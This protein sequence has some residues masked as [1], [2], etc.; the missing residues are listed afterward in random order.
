MDGTEPG[1]QPSS[2]HFS[3]SY[4]LSVLSMANRKGNAKSTTATAQV[5]KPEATQSARKKMRNA[6]SEQQENEAPSGPRA[7]K[8]T[9]L[10]NAVWKQGAPTGACKRA[11]SPSSMPVSKTKQ[12]EVQQGSFPQPPHSTASVTHCEDES[13][14]EEDSGAVSIPLRVPAAPKKPSKKRSAA[15]SQS[16]PKVTKDVFASDAEE[17]DDEQYSSVTETDSPFMTEPED[18]VQSDDDGSED[19]N[20]VAGKLTAAKKRF[21]EEQPSWSGD[22]NKEP[23]A[24]SP[25][26]FVIRG[27]PIVISSDDGDAVASPVSQ[28]FPTELL[29]V[30]EEPL[31]PSGVLNASHTAARANKKKQRL[32]AD[33]IWPEYTHVMRSRHD[34]SLALRYQGIELKLVLQKA[35]DSIEGRTRFR[36]AFPTLP[37]R[38]RWSRDCLEKAC[39]GFIASS[40]AGAKDKYVMIRK[41][42]DIDLQFFK[43]LS[44]LLSPRISSLRGVTKTHAVNSA[45]YT[46]NL[47]PGCSE[48]VRE[49]L[50][51]KNYIYPAA[52]NGQDYLR[53]KP[54][55]HKA[56]IRT[57]RETLFRNRTITQQFP[58]RF[59]PGEE[60]TYALSPAM[61]ALA[62]TA[63]F[64]ALK[65]WESGF[66]TGI[67]FM[68]NLYHGV[69]LDHIK[70]LNDIKAQKPLAYTS[71]LRRLFR[72][73]SYVYSDLIIEGDAGVGDTIGDIDNMAIDED[74]LE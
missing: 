53:E 14:T 73:A 63:V 10:K 17:S 35:M 61:V 30:K 33:S 18:L 25:G 67:Q 69:Y 49:L 5:D 65:E 66:R 45:L 56:I 47:H 16:R 1:V 48:T 7:A 22:E 51:K 74:L 34:N 71:L 42:L 31:Q 39:D 64:A 40:P 9:A 68:A 19:G 29:E 70:G 4:Y 32:L 46:Y 72:M 6:P 2:S 41:R 62:A 37:I 54:F 38:M 15:T 59:K 55:E 52:P 60:R 26:K 20:N 36:D 50:K 58:G 8:V 11:A 12:V 44:T 13:V 21:L 27:S 23:S 28:L 24:A 3:K 57:L 43:E